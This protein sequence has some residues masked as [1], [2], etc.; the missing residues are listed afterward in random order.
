MKIDGWVEAVYIDVIKRKASW[1]ILNK[2]LK[3]RYEK[4]WYSEDIG[5]WLDVRSEF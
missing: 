1:E 4:N 3:V 2:T 5:K